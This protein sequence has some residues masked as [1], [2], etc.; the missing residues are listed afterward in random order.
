M[1]LKGAIELDLFTHV[2]AG[3]A[4]V[5]EIAKRANASERGVR[6]L[7]DFLT[8]LGYL[9]KKDGTYSLSR[10]SAAF[11]DRKSPAYMG[12]VVNVLLHPVTVSNFR[13][14]AALVRA[15]KSLNDVECLGGLWVEFARSMASIMV[16]PAKQV[17]NVVGQPGR[18]LKVLDL[19]AGHGAFG[20]EIA[21]SNPDA[22]IYALDS[23]DVLDVA[24]E[25]A[26]RAGVHDRFHRINGSAF[27]VALGT[28]YDLILVTNFLHMF[29]ASELQPLL[30]RL[31]PALG[32]DGQVATVEFVPND[33]LV[34]PPI[35]ASFAMTM[36]ANT[37]RGD[38]YT[39]SEL[40][41]MFRQAGFGESTIHSLLPIP[42]SLVLTKK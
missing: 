16:W 7:C 11:L 31:R 20:I 36:L 13:D 26:L 15:G 17:A 34:S 9:Q 1:A 39:F 25:N 3:A 28:G 24:E 41:A 4:T 6:I 29:G 14:V 21:K 33:D 2:G 23:K 42:H 19:A 12:S 35:A 10:E 37:E 5:Q 22:V 8:I 27:D 40:S 18:S 30:K 38:V 32:S